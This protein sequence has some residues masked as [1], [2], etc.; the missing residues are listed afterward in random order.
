ML[1]YMVNKKQNHKKKIKFSM[2]TSSL[3]TRTK[4]PFI[5][6]SKTKI[7]KYFFLKIIQW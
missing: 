2:H 6:Y 4:F 3:F 7:K 1:Y 5:Y